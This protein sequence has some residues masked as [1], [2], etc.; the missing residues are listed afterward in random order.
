[1]KIIQFPK[2]EATN[3]K[4]ESQ[5]E[6]VG[7]LKHLLEQAEKGVIQQIGIIAIH[8]DRDVES[9]FVGVTDEVFHFIGYLE[10][11]KHQ[12]LHKLVEYE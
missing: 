7:L 10:A 5:S 12:A 6:I 2:R 4:A 8:A 1:M 3:E 11:L 9:G